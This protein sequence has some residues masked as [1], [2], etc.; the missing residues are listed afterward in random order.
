MTD[1]DMLAAMKQ[2]TANSVVLVTAM[3]G[4][5]AAVLDGEL[6]E[7]V[8]WIGV[9]PGTPEAQRL[10]LQLNQSTHLTT[11]CLELLAKAS[12]MTTEQATQR[13]AALIAGYNG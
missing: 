9:V 2:A 12:G 7:V 1:D 5:D 8:Q 3:Q 10:A 6:V 4:G 11:L 13:L